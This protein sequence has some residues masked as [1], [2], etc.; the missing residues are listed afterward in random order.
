MSNKGEGC[1]L[2]SAALPLVWYGTIDIP[3]TERV[4][5]IGHDIC[6]CGRD[7]PGLDDLSCLVSLVC[8][9]RQRRSMGHQYVLLGFFHS[10]NCENIIRKR[11]TN[12]KLKMMQPT[13]IHFAVL[14]GI[15]ITQVSVHFC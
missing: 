3:L 14:K 4:V 6:E 5:V 12:K 1:F 10:F 8:E 11:L 2:V 7:I 9:L 13:N 15:L